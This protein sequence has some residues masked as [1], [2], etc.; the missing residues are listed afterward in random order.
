MTSGSEE[1]WRTFSCFFQFREQVIVRRGQIRRIGWV[2]RT[3]EAQV[4]HFLLGCKCPVSRG[5]VVQEQDSLG[6][7]SAAFFL[8]NILQFHQ[9]RWV[10]LGVDNLA[11]WKIINVEVTIL[12]PKNRGE[13]FPADFCTRNFSGRVKPLCCH[14]IDCCFVSGSWWYNQVSSMVT[15]CNRKS[16]GSRRKNSKICS[17]DWHRWRFWSAFRLFRT[18][19]AESFHMSKSSWMV[20]PTRSREMPSCSAIGLGEIRRSSNIS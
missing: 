12:I 7:L 19:F 16:I 4:G 5:I 2:I 13:N 15:N 20:D 8:Q 14:S 1:K 3:L 9:Q 18:Y 10:I 17:D 11:L 6:E